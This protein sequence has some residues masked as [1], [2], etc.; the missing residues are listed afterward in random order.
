MKYLGKFL[1]YIKEN[2]GDDFSLSEIE[3]ILLPIQDLDVNYN[4]NFKLLT[5]GE[6]SG[7]NLVSIQFNISGFKKVSIAGWDNRIIDARIWELMEE[8]VMLMRR[9]ESDFSSIGFS[10]NIIAFQFVQK[11][12]V[13]DDDLFKIRKIYDEIGRRIHSSKSDFSNNMSRILNTE[14]L[15]LVITCYGYREGEYTDR[16]WNGFVRGIDFSN[17]NVDKQ[18]TEHKWG[19]K[20]VIITITVK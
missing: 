4:I 14:E 16:K 19:D 13:E 1:E 7:R 6:F 12:K 20:E 18:V 3:E 17:Y 10:N 8:I 11:S 5:D 9:I 15:K 2:R